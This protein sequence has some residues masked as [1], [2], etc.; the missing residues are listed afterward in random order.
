MKLSNLFFEC[1]NARYLW[2]I[3][4][5]TSGLTAPRNKTHMFGSW[6]NGVGTKLKHILLAGA[7]ALIWAI[8]LSRNEIVFDTTTTKPFSPKQVGVG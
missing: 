8:W 7:S 6:L 1:I 5:I 4:H 2:G 3:I